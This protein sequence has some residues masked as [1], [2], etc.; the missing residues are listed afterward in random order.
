MR[1]KDPSCRPSGRLR[2]RLTSSRSRALCWSSTCSL[3]WR[4]QRCLGARCTARTCHEM[5]TATALLLRPVEWP[6][7]TCRAATARL[8]QQRE[9]NI[10]QFN[11]S[12]QRQRRSKCIGMP[13]EHCV[14]GLRKPHLGRTLWSGAS[15]YDHSAQRLFFTAA[16]LT[17]PGPGGTRGPRPRALRWFPTGLRRPRPRPA[18]TAAPPAA[19][20][21]QRRRNSPPRDAALARSLGYRRRPRGVSR[22][23]ADI[24]LLF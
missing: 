19:P 1:G 2:S 16:S 6:P 24:D 17:P 9:S 21:F 3:C 15:P 4:R 10:F 18:A 5:R 14:A 23:L 13:I 11:G 8:R 20:A 12:S 7:S 22:R